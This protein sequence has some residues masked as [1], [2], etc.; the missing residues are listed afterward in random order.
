MEFW[1]DIFQN[2]EVEQ[3]WDLYE[4]N[5]ATVDSSREFHR[6][7]GNLLIIHLNNNFKKI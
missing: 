7:S 5:Q 1:S 3:S 4:N 6:H 2:D